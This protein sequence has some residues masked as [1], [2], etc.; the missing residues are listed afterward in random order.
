MRKQVHLPAQVVVV[1]TA[2]KAAAAEEGSQQDEA[3]R[4]LTEGERRASSARGSPG[5][6]DDTVDVA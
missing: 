1:Q 4:E 5:C 2:A 6:N 3:R